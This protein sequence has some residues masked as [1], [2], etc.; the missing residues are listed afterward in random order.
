[1][2]VTAIA[3]AGTRARPGRR[4][5]MCDMSTPDQEGPVENGEYCTSEEGSTPPVTR[6][7]EKEHRSEPREAE[8][9]SAGTASARGNGLAFQVPSPKPQM[10]RRSTTCVTALAAALLLHPGVAMGG[11]AVPPV[12]L[13]APSGPIVHVSTLAQLQNAVAGI[14]SNTTIVIAPGTYNLAD[15]ALHQRHLHQRRHPGRDRQPR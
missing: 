15:T 9:G 11:P 10:P 1:M 5:A 6:N 2:I 8:P 4:P 12:P 3:T 7:R 14:A 13:P